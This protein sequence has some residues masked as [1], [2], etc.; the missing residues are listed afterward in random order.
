MCPLNERFSQGTKFNKLLLANKAVVVR[1]MDPFHVSHMK[2]CRMR[3]VKAPE[4][5]AN[6]QSETDEKPH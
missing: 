6:I 3:K 1:N 5:R 2:M 4:V